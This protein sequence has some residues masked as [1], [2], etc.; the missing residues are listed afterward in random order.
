MSGQRRVFI[1]FIKVCYYRQDHHIYGLLT[2]T[3]P[4]VNEILTKISGTASPY[5][6]YD[7]DN[8]LRSIQRDREVRS[9]PIWRVS[10]QI[11]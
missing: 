6:E 11:Y 7:R 2:N 8:E 9:L 5:Y 10:L 3:D 1:I 4:A